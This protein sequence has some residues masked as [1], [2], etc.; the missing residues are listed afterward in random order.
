MVLPAP[1]SLNHLPLATVL[2]T[3]SKAS[4]LAALPKEAQVLP[5]RLKSS[6]A[7]LACRDICRLPVHLA[8]TRL[9]L[10]LTTLS[11]TS[12]KDLTSMA[13]VLSRRNRRLHQAQVSRTLV[14]VAA[15]MASQRLSR[16]NRIRTLA[17][18]A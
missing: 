8:S 16:A 12:L 13:T 2:Q 6:K 1:R 10:L 15:L 11:L 18:L 14:L 7:S 3:S 9:Q 4:W 5:R 17:H